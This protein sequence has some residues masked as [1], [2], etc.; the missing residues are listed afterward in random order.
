M[1]PKRFSRLLLLFKRYNLKFIIRR[2]GTLFLFRAK[3]RGVVSNTNDE[4]DSVVW[5]P[6]Q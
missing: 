2:D 1:V 3:F 5:P 6:F 4:E